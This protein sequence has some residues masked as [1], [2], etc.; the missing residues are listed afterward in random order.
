[1]EENKKQEKK[2]QSEDFQL[3]VRIKDTDIDGNKKLIIGLTRIKGVGFNLSHALCRVLKVDENV[4]VG[5]LSEQE[6][7]K[8]E[9][10][11]E[12]PAKFGIPTWMFNREKDYDSGK[13]LHITTSELIFQKKE[14]LDRLGAIKSYRGLRHARGLKVRG[15]RTASTG[16]GKTA[17]GVQRRK[18][19]KAGK[20]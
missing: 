11:I 17:V 19:M 8:I 6:I 10:V 14:D 9:S 4:K 13:D 3:I 15:Q 20:T 1:M 12:D 16:R 2:E 5:G 7:Q 18:G